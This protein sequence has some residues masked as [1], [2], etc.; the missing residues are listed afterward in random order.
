MKKLK[1]IACVA[2]MM[3]IT[4]WA[5]AQNVGIGTA[6]PLHKLDIN[7]D[8]GING[9]LYISGNPGAS[10][11]VLVSGGTSSAPKWITPTKLTLY[12]TS[13]VLVRDTIQSVLI[14]GL[15]TNITLA[16]DATIEISTNGGV[17]T[18]SGLTNG[19]ST[20]GISV[21]VDGSV[22][23]G[24]CE[25]LNCINNTGLTGTYGGRWALHIYVPLTAGTHT[26]S[27]YANGC[28]SGGAPLFVSDPWTTVY[29]PA[30]QGV[31]SIAY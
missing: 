23:K 20:I 14:P 15:S 19:Y 22:I 26:I 27:V 11:A 31:L 18:S 29:P 4:F 30:R 16:A 8:V 2:I 9:P 7:G 5:M 24:G 6:S 13:M 1:E 21:V 28:N 10:G 3:V 17:Q 25:R 12:G